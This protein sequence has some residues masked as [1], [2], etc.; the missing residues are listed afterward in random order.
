MA[1]LVYKTRRNLGLR[2]LKTDENEIE[3]LKITAMFFNFFFYV[4]FGDF[5]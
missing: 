1:V 2:T 4:Y 5:G 3:T